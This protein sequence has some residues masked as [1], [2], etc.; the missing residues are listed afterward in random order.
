MSLQQLAEET[1]TKITCK[2]TREVSGKMKNITVKYRE[3]TANIVGVEAGT[4]KKC[5]HKSKV[6]LRGRTFEERNFTTFLN[7]LNK[8]HKDVYNPNIDK[9]FEEDAKEQ[10][11]KQ[12]AQNVTKPF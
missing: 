9:A 6:P 4:L 3:C 2:E 12:N 7:H 1:H 8:E 11:M 5:G 10:K